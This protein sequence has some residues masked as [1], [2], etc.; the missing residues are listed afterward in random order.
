MKK[1]VGKDEIRVMV[2]NSIREEGLSE[3][4]DST[5]VENIVD[6]IMHAYK[7]DSAKAEIPEIIP[8]AALGS[9]NPIA[10]FP[11]MEIEDEEEPSSAPPYAESEMFAK[12]EP[13]KETIYTPEQTSGNIPA[14][15]PELPSFMEKIEPEKVIVFNQNELSDS[16]ENLSYKPLRLFSNPDERKSMKDLWLDA[17]KKKAD[18]YIAKFERIGEIEYDFINGSSVFREH[19]VEI[20]THTQTYQENPYVAKSMPETVSNSVDIKKMIEDTI[21]ELMKDK[22]YKP[23][24]VGESAVEELEPASEHMIFSNLSTLSQQAKELLGL[25]RASV[26]ARISDGHDWVRDHASTASSELSK[27]EQFFKNRTSGLRENNVA[28]VDNYM[29]FRNLES[30]VK[31]ADSIL[32]MDK[33]SIEDIILDD[34]SWAPDLVTQAKDD[35]DEVYKFLTSSQDINSSMQDDSEPL[36]IKMMDLVNED[37]GF[38][39]INTP[40]ALK[41]DFERSEKKYLISENEEVQEW[42]F[43]GESYYT[44]KNK[45]STK[46]CYF[47][48]KSLL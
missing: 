31:S 20:P 17:G 43:N 10:T 38:R 36:N 11:Y 6:N 28:E 25:E 2:S 15:K 47:R 7:V 14:Y 12:P 19:A 35:I 44:P 32:S 21:M 5:N 16:G 3:V 4:L 34:H 9:S 24:V 40:D 18:V 29:F 33:K 42:M 46:K 1:L 41:E 23:M 8:E 37:A 27:V 22:P 26:D 39:K 13:E 45:I 48:D 30:I